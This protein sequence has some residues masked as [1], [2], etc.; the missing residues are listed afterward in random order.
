MTKISR[1]DSLAMGPIYCNNQ[2]GQNRQLP[3]TQYFNTDD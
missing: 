1:N 3:I 2:Q